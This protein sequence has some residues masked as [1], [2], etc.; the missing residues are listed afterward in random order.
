MM[1]SNIVVL[2]VKKSLAGFTII[3]VLNVS[4]YILQAISS[5]SPAERERGA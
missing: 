4:N 1:A 2:I 5:L 3:A